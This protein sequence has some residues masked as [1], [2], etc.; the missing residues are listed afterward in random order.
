MLVELVV[1]GVLIGVEGVAEEVL[2][3][4]QSEETFVVLLLLED[5]RRS[6]LE[7]GWAR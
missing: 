4:V 3:R 5:G 1:G 6:L 7:V 2:W